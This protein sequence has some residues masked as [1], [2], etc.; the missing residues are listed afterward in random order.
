MTSRAGYFLAPLVFLAGLALAG[1]FVWSGVT[2]LQN[3]FARV[4]VPG[5]TVLTLDKPGTYT[6]FHESESVVD[7]KIYAASDIAGLQ[8]AVTGAADGKTIPVDAPSVSSEYSAGG[9]SGRSLLEF[10]IV[11]PGKYK[12][13]ATYSSGRSEPQ[14]VLAI[15]SGFAGRLVRTILGALAAAFLGFGIALAL[16]LTTYFRRRRLRAYAAARP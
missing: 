12:L 16:I 9:H 4:V 3:A 8:V 1:W 14:T 13:S 2:D 15:S 6:I 10:D 5:A 7:G 11:T